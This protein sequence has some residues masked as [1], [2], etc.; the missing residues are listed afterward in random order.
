MKINSNP[1][2]GTVDIL[3]NEAR[4]R[5]K[6]KEIILQTYT[7]YGFSQI[8]TPILEDINLLSGGDSGDNTKLMFKVL[9][10][11]E[12]LDLEN[13]KTENDLSDIALRYDL[14]VPLAR[15]Y[16]NNQ[17]DLPVPFKSIQIDD[18]FRAERPQKGRLRQFTQ[19]DI[20]IL[21]D[22]SVNAD[23]EVVYVSSVAMQN[24]GFKNFKYKI[25]DRRVLNEVIVFCGFDENECK[26]ICITLDK[27]DKIELD[28]VKDELIQKGYSEKNVQNLL[29]SISEIQ[30]NGLK[31]LK[32]F[33][34]EPA[35]IESLN[36][37]IRTLNDLSCGKFS[38]EF[39]VS[40]V[41]GQG[42]YTGMVAEIYCDGF[43]GACGGGGRYN[44]MIENFS[45]KSVSAVGFSIGFERICMILNEN[46][47]N[48]KE[49]IALLYCEEDCIEN[50]FKEVEKM[51][52]DFEVIA[53]CK[54]KNLSSQLDKLKNNGFS[55]FRFLD[56]DL[57]K[58]F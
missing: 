48:L 58:R 50:I 5:E 31:V 6:V 38:A 43:A 1:V 52:K 16:C 21:G 4:T 25:S 39:D 24:L 3:P 49:R 57:I 27:L 11:G 51:Q 14:T 9:K 46:Q 29:S 40:I 26:N 20:D 10:R 34:V 23:I 32:N 53:V 37:I 19:C 30:K 55:G 2:R 13:A 7:S 36:K 35:V 42:Y 33:G 45:G 54:Q 8:K 22:N 17:N 44:N 12:K 15:F 28:G 56:S 41:R 47:I 18:V